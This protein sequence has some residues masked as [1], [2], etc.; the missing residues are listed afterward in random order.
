M[1][2]TTD[3]F[4]KA[5]QNHYRYQSAFGI[6]TTEDLWELPL[7]DRNK[8]GG[9][10]N[11]IAKTIS[12]S[13]RAAQEEDFVSAR[14][15]DSQGLE[16]RLEVVKRI[17]EVKQQQQEEARNAVARAAQR[18]KLLGV[19]ADKQDEELRGMSKEEIQSMIDSM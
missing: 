5:T 18:Q 1:T 9:D 3:L 15:P 14:T 7:L 19:L 2:D 8:N 13:L 4:Q 6:L 17:I 10:L 12:R 11:T 16:D